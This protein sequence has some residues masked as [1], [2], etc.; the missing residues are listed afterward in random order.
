M[1]DH[2]GI[3][4]VSY[5]WA[6]RLKWLD[7]PFPIEEYEDR[8][9]RLRMAMAGRGLE[10]LL[11]YGCP[12][13]QGSVRWVSNFPS[14][15][16]NTI[17]VL[18]LE[19]E[20]VL[21]TD[22]VMHSEP[23]HTQIW[24]SWIKDVR[25][26]HHTATI[27]AAENIIDYVND[28][29]KEIGCTRGKIGVVGERWM[30]YRMMADLKERL[31]NVIFEPATDLFVNAKRL[32]TPR[33]IAFIRRV[34]LQASRG[35][36]AVM[37]A[38]TE[39]IT[40][41]ELAAIAAETMVRSGAHEVRSV[42]LASGPRAGLKHCYPTERKLQKGDMLFVDL[43]PVCYGYYSDV[44]RTFIL[45]EGDEEK[46]KMQETAL[47]MEEVVIEN[48][49]PGAR[50]CDLQSIAEEIAKKAGY[51]Q[52]YYPT[53]FGHGIAT[54]LTEM[55][56]LF[57]DNEAPLE[58]GMTFALEPMIVIE[59]VGTACYEDVLLVTEDGCEQLSDARKLI[60]VP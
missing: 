21:A 43:G 36:D 45:A 25:W 31:S 29:V 1:T 58:A 3:S 42:A 54:S 50:I 15:F 56:A 34:A 12:N 20:P 16:G 37:D 5:D 7:L 35:L 32:R 39:G 51:Q 48:I 2:Y 53:G 57:P 4:K 8:I 9:R 6:N 60:T 14:F 30:P 41:L 19:G 40:E 33:E 38:A 26:A 24:T 28:S 52:Y 55:P 17:V 11:I 46:R 23:M 59:G 10:A 18:G 13:D 49:R 47:S 44:C 27:R 22:S